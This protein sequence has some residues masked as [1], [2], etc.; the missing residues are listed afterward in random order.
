[1]GRRDAVCALCGAPVRGRAATFDL[2]LPGGGRVPLAGVTTIGR[3][4]ESTVRLEDRTVSRAHA[5]VRV[6]DDGPV[7][8]DAGSSHGTLVDGRPVGGPTA[9][10]DGATIAV[11]DVE[12]RLERHRDASEAGRTIVVPANGSV[13]VDAA[14][15][16][17]VRQPG[18]QA[19]FRPAMR[20][21]W[22][23]KRLEA[24]EGRLRW[25]LSSEHMPELLRMGEDEAALVQMLDGESSLPELMA[26]S[27]RR[28]GDAGVTRLAGLLATL[29]ERGLLEGVDGPGAHAR[30]GWLARLT[31]P[32]EKT[33][34][35]A[36]AVFERLYRGGGWV[37]FTRAALVA[38][39]VVAVAGLTA[40]TALIVGRG[41]TPFVVADRIGLGGIVFLMGRFLVVVIHELAHGLAMASFGRRVPRAGLKTIIGIPFAFV[42]TTEAWFEPRRRRIAISAAGPASDVVVGGVAAL[43]ALA[44]DAGN[45]RDIVYQVALAAYVGAFYNLN[46][47]LDR[48]GYHMLVDHLGEPGLRRRARERLARR[49]AGRRPTAGD[50]SRAI[51]IYGVASLVWMVLAA[52]FVIILSLVYFDR[53]TAI[54]PPEVVWAVLGAF[55]LLLFLP[56]GFV[57]GRPLMARRRAGGGEVAGAAG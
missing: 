39:A 31:R 20:P 47:M 22:R 46:P 44:L 51:A 10:R 56:V 2:V 42:D 21:G 17:R 52:G 16:A 15:H 57:L 7:L 34:P 53:L 27:E 50:T 13:V 5:R 55:Y 25:V 33:L 40:F 3:S 18:T 41:G 19:G 26:E 23:L 32:R 49:L 37:L 54:A 6:G 48:D 36:G 30:D 43:A 8:E 28:Y 24:G 38:L 45:L 35:G 29:G 9:L 1:V 14:G 4:P 11:G 12:L